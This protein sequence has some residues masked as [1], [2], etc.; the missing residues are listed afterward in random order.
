M[1]KAGATP[2]EIAALELPHPGE[3]FA[4]LW[5]MFLT[6]SKQS[7]K[8]LN[9][10]RMALLKLGRKPEAFAIVMLEAAIQGDWSGVENPGTARAFEEWQVQQAKAPA[11]VATPTTS[12][13]TA[14]LFARKAPA[15]ATV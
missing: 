10:H 8:S 7:G 5:A 6:G 15:P 3:E 9:A 11:P 2:E 4:N 14:D 12:Y 13:N 1:K